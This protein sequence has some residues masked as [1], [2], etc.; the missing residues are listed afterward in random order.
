MSAEKILKVVLYWHMHPFLEE[1][2]QDYL[3]QVFTRGKGVPA[4]GG[5]MRPGQEIL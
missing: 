5:T 4:M 2:L 1:Q 3:H